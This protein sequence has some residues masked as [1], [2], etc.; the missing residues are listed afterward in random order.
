[1]VDRSVAL[2]ALFLA[3]GCGPYDR[4]PEHTRVEQAYHYCPACRSLQGGIYGQG[5]FKRFSGPE[6]ASCR[7]DGWPLTR[8]AFEQLATH[9][10]G[11]TWED[12]IP[13][14]LR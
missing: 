14:W 7:H 5:P 1:M 6:R 12:E 4:N 10:Y 9:Q 2:L 8:S 13:F 11:V 3:A